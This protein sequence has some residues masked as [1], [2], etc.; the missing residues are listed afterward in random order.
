[1]YAE[2]TIDQGAT[3]EE[4]I[5]LE[6]DDGTPVNLA[7]TSFNAQIRKSY[8]ST[9]ITANIVVTIISPNTNGQ[10]QLSLSAANTANIKAGRYLYDLKMINSAN[11]VTRVV[12]GIATVTPQIT[13]T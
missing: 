3:F 5:D 9:N 11:V 8:Y 2:L 4:T 13:K 6:N 1:M 12:E 10:V 7:N